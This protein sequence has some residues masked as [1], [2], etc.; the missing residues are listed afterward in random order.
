MRVFVNRTLNMKKIKAIGFDMDYTLVR[1][2]TEQFEELTYKTILNKLVSLKGYAKEILSF[3][4]DANKVIQGLVIDKRRGNVV[5]LS[6]YGKVKSSWH[7]NKRLSFEEQEAQY[8]VAEIELSDQKIQSLDT[9]FSVAHGVL[10]GN[11]VELKDQRPELNLSDYETIAEDIRFCLDIAH[12][13]GSLKDEVRKNISKY[14]IQDPELPSLLETYKEYGKKLII[15]TN[16]DFSYSKLLL[17]YTINPFLHNHKD[18]SE[19]FEVVV[20]L[21]QKPRFFYDSLAYLKIDPNT[22]L[23]SNLEGPLVSGIYQGG[24]AKQM[25]ADLG[26]KANEILYLGDHIFGDVVSL[27]KTVNWQT[28][29]IFHPLEEEMIAIT[30]GAETQKRIDELMHQKIILEDKLNISYLPRK[31]HINLNTE[32]KEK[33]FA[34]KNEL[35]NEIEKINSEISKLIEKYQALFN[36]SWGEL[37]RAG[38]EESRLAGHIEKYATI[39]MAKVSD[40]LECSPRTYFRPIRRIL[41]HEHVF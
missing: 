3:E 16:S 26:L 34:Q 20:T 19:L 36:P 8:G 7:G 38:N 35:F 17:D 6:R 33:K 41:A 24:N 25:Q 10:Y 15:I 32:E 14:I 18:W 22:A 39:Y 30:K 37:M 27:K 4:F 13:D 29:L 1:Y 11:L 2:Y 23:M 31:A 28:G 5:K 40:L 21:S 12:R 9:S